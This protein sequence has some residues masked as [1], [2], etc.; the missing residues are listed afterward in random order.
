M[1]LAALAPVDATVFIERIVRE[2]DVADRRELGIAL[3]TAMIAKTFLL[4]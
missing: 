4:T 2:G 1:R 3:F